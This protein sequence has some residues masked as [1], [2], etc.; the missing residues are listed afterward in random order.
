M[1][2][3]TLTLIFR[4]LSIQTLQLEIDY[5]SLTSKSS[6]A[7]AADVAHMEHQLVLMATNMEVRGMNNENAQGLKNRTG[8]L[9]LSHKNM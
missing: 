7:E 4:P 9:S 8:F 5:K 6:Q 1:R 2:F 3:L